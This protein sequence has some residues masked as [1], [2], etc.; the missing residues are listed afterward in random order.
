MERGEQICLRTGLENYKKWVCFQVQCDI[1]APS[2]TKTWHVALETYPCVSQKHTGRLRQPPCPSKR[3]LRK[4]FL[5]SNQTC[6]KPVKT[7]W[8]HYPLSL[9]PSCN[10]KPDSRGPKA[11]SHMAEESIS[12][13]PKVIQPRAGLAM[14]CP[15]PAAGM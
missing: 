9:Q 8:L 3:L 1:M 2:G 13:F 5:P 7:Q 14:A 6:R 15:P 11:F 4:G 10:I 12:Y